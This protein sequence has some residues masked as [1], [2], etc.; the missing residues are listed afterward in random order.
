VAHRAPPS[1]AYPSAGTLGWTALAALVLWTMIAAS[2]RGLR[3]ATV[4]ALSLGGLVPAAMGLLGLATAIQHRRGARASG[5]P[6][7]ERADRH[8]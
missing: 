5:P 3:S 1:A 8:E 2:G 7:R 4:W 6:P